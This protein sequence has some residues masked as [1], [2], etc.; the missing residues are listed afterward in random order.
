MNSVA[1]DGLNENS[2]KKIKEIHDREIET[3][4]SRTHIYPAH[5]HI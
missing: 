2:C 3:S 4:L 1:F 5:I